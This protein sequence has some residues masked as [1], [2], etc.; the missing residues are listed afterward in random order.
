MLF[1]VE[2]NI[3]IH[4]TQVIH[5]YEADYNM[6]FGLKWREALYQAEES[7]TLN[8]MGNM[9]PADHNVTR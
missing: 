6:M 1:K 9:G 2:N 7:S 3:G 8:T 4:H 5:I